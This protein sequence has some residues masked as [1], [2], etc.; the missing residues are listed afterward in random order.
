[1]PFRNKTILSIILCTLCLW[2]CMQEDP[3]LEVDISKREPV[4]I[5]M[6]TDVITY[7]YLPQYSHTVSYQRHHLLVKYLRRETGLNIKQIFPDTFHEH[8]NRVGQGKIDIS[9]SNP[10]IYVKIAAKY[11]ARAFARIVEIDGGEKFRGQIICRADNQAIRTINDCRKKRW[12]AVDP[13]SAG[14][15][16]YPLGHFILRGIK[17]ESFAEIAFAPGPGGKQ[18][19]VVLAVHAGEY[20]I[21]TIREGTLKVVA[22]KIDINEIRIV[23]NTRWYPGW[24]YAARTGL[25]S[26]TVEKIKAAFLKLDAKNSESRLVLEA[27]HFADIIPSQDV[28]FAPVRELVSRIG[29]RLEM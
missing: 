12:I 16:L 10:F 15:Y 29:L 18:E 21:G 17:P 26:E 28:E 27:A 3:P 19:K 9:F 2:G 22:D 5:K 7:A 4:R 11:G 20:D 24:V 13:A 6:E 25:P 14:G 23:E 1:M 8:M